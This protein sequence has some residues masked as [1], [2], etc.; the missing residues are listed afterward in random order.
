MYSWFIAYKYVVSRLITVVALLAVTFSV[1]VLIVVVSVMEG[2]RTGLEQRIRGST[3]DIKIE[4]D[5]F[6]GLESPAAIEAKLREIPGVRATAPVVETFALYSPGG[7]TNGRAEAVDHYLVA[8]DLGNDLARL[9]L[10][11]AL[12]ALPDRI[13]TQRL[14]NPAERRLVDE[15]VRSQPRTVDELFSADWL[16]D[17]LWEPWKRLDVPRPVKSLKPIVVGIESFRSELLLPGMV[18]RLTSFAPDVREPLEEAFLVAGFFKTGLY[19]TDAKG[20]ILRLEDAEEFL[21]LRD[22]AGTLSVSGIRI[23]AEEAFQ[24][25]ESLARLR[26]EVERRLEENGVL[27]ATAQTW[28]EA[29]APLLAAVKV[30]KVIVSIILGAVILF[31][32]FMIFIILTVQVVEKS[33]DIGVLQSLGASARGIAAIYFSIGAGL[34]AAGMVFGTIYGV[35]I[36]LAI[37]TI[38]RWVKLLTGLELFPDDVY[39]LDRIPVKFRADDLAFIILAT[40][41]AS[42]IASVLPAMRAA[43]RNPTEGLRHG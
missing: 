24:D 12:D 30:E 6:I 34:C 7:P 19:E 1:A 32:G 13:E 42:L 18:I 16:E 15:L 3:S 20:M 9:E 22:A 27:F 40:V 25:T 8:M 39:Y 43:R 17:R 2:F 23:A 5:I 28:R 33:R 29:R 4:S 36:G 38:Q 41:A 10:Q 37:N 35:S 26:A 11:A 14:V 31:A 21:H